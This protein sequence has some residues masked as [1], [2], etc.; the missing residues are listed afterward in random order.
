VL[1]VDDH[2]E[3]RELMRRSLTDA[4]MQV[5][6]A[7]G[8]REALE[9]ALAAEHDLVVTDLL[10]PEMSGFEL[11]YR[12]RADDRTREVP[13]VVFTGKDLSDDDRDGLIRGQIQQLLEKGEAGPADLVSI[14]RETLRTR[15]R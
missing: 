15:R 1:V 12:L 8:G 7:G 10:M 13:I 4:G 11:I 6:V 5:A 2:P 14:V 3:T 9:L